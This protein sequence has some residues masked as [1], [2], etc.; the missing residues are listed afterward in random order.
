MKEA[1]PGLDASLFIDDSGASFWLVDE[2]WE[3]KRDYEYSFSS[4]H[5]KTSSGG[6]VGV[7]AK[8]DTLG[9][10]LASRGIQLSL[11]EPAKGG[12]NAQR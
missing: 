3:S 9:E 4:K 5:S 2:S 11:G 10:D 1:I 8:V 7:Q 12:D 6:R